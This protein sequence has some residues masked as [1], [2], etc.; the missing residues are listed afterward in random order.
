MRQAAKQLASSQMSIDQ[1]ARSVGYESRSSFIR[2]FVKSF[3]C[4]PTEYRTKVKTD[5]FSKQRSSESLA[6]ISEVAIED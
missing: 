3:G 5:A 1:I 4:E 2:A 6:A